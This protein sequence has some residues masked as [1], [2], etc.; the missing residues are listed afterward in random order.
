MRGVV[1]RHHE[2]ATRFFIE[3]MNNPGPLLAADAGEAGAVMKQGVDQGMRLVTR[4]W[5][6]NQ[7]S[8]LV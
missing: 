5:V 2:T 1:F 7:A 4:S 8:R 3:A 6:N